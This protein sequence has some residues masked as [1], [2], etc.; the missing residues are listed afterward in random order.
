[1]RCDQS[2]IVSNLSKNS[3]ESVKINWIGGEESFR[4]DKSNIDSNQFIR[5]FI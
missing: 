3:I 5:Y 2:V 4:V 1:M